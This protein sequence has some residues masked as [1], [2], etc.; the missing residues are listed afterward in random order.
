MLSRAVLKK[1]LQKTIKTI[2]NSCTT[3][4]FSYICSVNMDIPLVYRLNI[5]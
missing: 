4:F 3:K 5:I 2:K 1:K